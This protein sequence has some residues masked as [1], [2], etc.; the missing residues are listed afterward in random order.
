LQYARKLIG[1]FPGFCML[2]TSVAW[3]I[4]NLERETRVMDGSHE[5]EDINPIFALAHQTLI[6]NYTC[7]REVTQACK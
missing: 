6:L 1:V 3:Q 2:I 7:E 4:K 5:Q